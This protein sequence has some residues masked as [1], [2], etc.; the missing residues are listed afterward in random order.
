MG[1]EPDPEEG[2]GKLVDG[3]LS[4]RGRADADPADLHPRLPGR[5]V[6]VRQAPPHRA[7]G[8]VERWEAFVGGFEIANAFTEL[9]DPDE[10]RRA[11]R[12]AGRASFA[13]ATRRRSRSTRTSSR[14]LE[15]GMPPT[16]GRR[17][18]DRP[19]GDAAHRGADP[20]RGGAV[21]G[22][23][24]LTRPRP[25]PPRCSSSRRSRPDA[26][27]GRRQAPRLRRAVPV[28][29]LLRDAVDRAGPLPRRR[30]RLPQRHGHGRLR[31]ARSIPT[32]TGTR[33]SCSPAAASVTAPGSR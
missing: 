30:R 27:T 18:R 8:L 11:L 3:L 28:A 15:Q 13:A 24:R 23:A 26:A 25:A 7:D 14:A 29:G 9:N 22:D 21:P 19:A 16:G 10:Q 12:A 31:R 2:W 6:A 32:A 17:P 4:K 20:A 33:T 1:T 5:A